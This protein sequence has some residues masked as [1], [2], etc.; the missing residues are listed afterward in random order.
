[1]VAVLTDSS[2]PSGYLKDM[3]RRDPSL[4]EVFK[5]GAICPPP[6]T[7]ILQ[8]PEDFTIKFSLIEA[9]G[10]IEYRYKYEILEVNLWHLYQ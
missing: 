3:R 1:M 10:R 2:N 4:A 9:S 5:G 8:R 6:L 7:W